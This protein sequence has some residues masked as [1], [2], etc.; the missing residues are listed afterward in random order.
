MKDEDFIYP[1]TLSWQEAE[2][3][4]KKV[5]DVST[6]LGGLASDERLRLA[7]YIHRI[8]FHFGVHPFWPL[9]SLQREQG[10]ITDTVSTRPWAYQAA[11][12]VVGQDVA[13]SSKPQFHGLLN[14]LFICIKNASWNLGS[15]DQT[16]RLP[17]LYGYRP[18]LYPSWPRWGETDQQGKTGRVEILDEPSFVYQCQSRAEYCQLKHCPHMGTLKDNETILNEIILPRWN[19][20]G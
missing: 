14:Q 19:S 16:I 1:E 5:I 12:G 2:T 9:A 17:P 15:E 20:H 11:C 18:G 8:C 3:R 4:I 7:L 13:G 6:G 10:L